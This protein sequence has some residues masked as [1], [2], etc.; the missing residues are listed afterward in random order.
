MKR[1]WKRTVVMLKFTLQR[2][3]YWCQL[4]A[5]A[6]I[7]AGVLKPY[8][9]NI[10]LWLLALIAFVIFITVGIIDKKIRLL[11]EEQSYITEQNPTLMKGL[12]LFPGESNK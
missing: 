3:Y 2:G 11:H 12:G 9:P 8:F 4:P 6:I 10:S 1:S 5:L 7:G